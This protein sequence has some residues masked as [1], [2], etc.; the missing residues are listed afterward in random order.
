[1]SFYVQRKTS[2]NPPLINHGIIN[3]FIIFIIYASILILRFILFK[4][5]DILY[6]EVG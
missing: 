2:I 6:I 5:N 4:S 3:V 1:M